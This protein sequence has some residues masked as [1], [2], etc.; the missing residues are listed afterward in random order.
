MDR[1]FESAQAARGRAGRARLPVGQGV[2]QRQVPRGL[3]AGWSS[4]GPKKRT[5]DVHVD[6][7]LLFGPCHTHSYVDL[8]VLR[9]RARLTL[10]CRTCASWQ[11]RPA[12][13]SPGPP[14]PLP[15][16]KND[17]RH[18]F[19]RQRP[20]LLPATTTRASTR[21]TPSKT[22]GLAAGTRGAQSLATA[23]RAQQP[24]HERANFERKQ[25]AVLS[26]E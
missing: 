10:S 12:W 6:P 5:N 7:L 20:P 21:R 18:P 3:Q 24:G 15:S 13:T 8:F 16:K 17:E 4:A 2:R 22:T 1:R 19:A 26:A 11:R 25:A 14:L 23:S 9:R